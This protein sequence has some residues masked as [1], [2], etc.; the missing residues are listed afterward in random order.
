MESFW[1][2]FDLKNF[3]SI[4]KIKN[5]KKFRKYLKILLIKFILWKDFE[6]NKIFVESVVKFF[7]KFFGYN[8]ICGKIGKI[9]KIDLGKK[10][11]MVWFRLGYDLVS[12]KCGSLG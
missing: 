5:I 12:K 9:K 3:K 8:L 2:D 11:G 10:W 4:L 6:T 1:K 7:E